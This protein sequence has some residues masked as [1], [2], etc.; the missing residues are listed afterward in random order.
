VQMVL[1]TTG[2]LVRKQR[3]EVAR[4]RLI[5]VDLPT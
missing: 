1:P 2:I 3:L 4:L 5:K